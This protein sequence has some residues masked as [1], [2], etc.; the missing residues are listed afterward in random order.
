LYGGTSFIYQIDTNGIDEAQKKNLSTKTISV[1]KKRLDPKNHLNLIWQP[2]GD[3]SFE[4][5]MP[6]PP[7]RVQKK[8]E[9]YKTAYEKLLAEKIEPGKIMFLSIWPDKKEARKEFEKMAQGSSHKL[10]TIKS[11]S[12]AF[13]DFLPFLG[14]Y[15][16]NVKKYD[17][18]FVQYMIKGSGVLEFRVLPTSGNLKIDAN[19]IKGYIE[20]FEKL[21]PGYT[22]DKK[23]IWC[24]VEK[25]EEL[26]H[27]GR[28]GNSQIAWRDKDGNPVYAETFG[29][30]WYVL[31][32]NKPEE[33][34]LHSP[35]NPWKLKKATPGRDKWTGRN[36][37]DFELDPKGGAIFAK[38]TEANIGR[39]LCILLDNL[40][41]SAPNINSRIYTNG[42]ITGGSKGFTQNQQNDMV[43][44][45]NAG[46]L[47]ANLI[48]TPISIKTIEAKQASVQK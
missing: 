34:M 39:P 17:P 32:S 29:N 1:L 38:I 11:F 31:A 43:N 15:D 4:I 6:L 2:R 36:G 23:F 46:V 9:D 47:P 3:A 13:D 24:K 28:D 8:W 30:K 25:G 14:I 21:G 10:D 35:Q 26:F 33:C 12:K 44:K 48:E 18:N 19:E 27:I 7:L 20:Q 41:V 40:A 5:Q 16:P 45:L 42:Q 37:I 22:Q